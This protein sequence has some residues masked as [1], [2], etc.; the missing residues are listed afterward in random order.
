[1]EA[2]PRARYCSGRCR[3]KA[4]RERNGLYS[5][6]VGRWEYVQCE[7]CGAWYHWERARKGQERRYC[8]AS[9]SQRAYR[10][11]VKDR[12]RRRSRSRGQAGAGSSSSSAGG[13]SGSSWSSSSS[14][15]GSSYGSAGS[16]GSSSSSGGGYGF[17]R[18]STMTA[19]EARAVVFAMAELVDDDT[20]TLRKAYR[21]AARLHHPDTNGNDGE[22]FKQL[23]AAAFVLRQAGLL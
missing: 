15:A 1:M 4:F 12:E 17:G 13:S 6:H 21:R 3:Q 9:C 18:R 7:T 20:V 22:A 11:R 19:A 10:E 16:S 5:S 8:S 2:G 14:G 23:E